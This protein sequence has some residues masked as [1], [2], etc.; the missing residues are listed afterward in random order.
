MPQNLIKNPPKAMILAA[1]LGTRLR[2]LTN[3]TPKA[4][5]QLQGHPLIAYSLRLLKKFGIQ[6]VLINLHHLGELIEKELG[7]GRKFGMKITYSW[8]PHVLGTGGGLKKAEPFFEGKPFLLMNSD[9]LIDLNLKE[10]LQFHRRKK[11]LATMV[12]RPKEADSSFT[13]IQLDRSNRVL[14]IGDEPVKK[15]AHEV[16]FTGLQILEPAFL[17]YIPSDQEACLIRNGYNPALKNSEKIY[18]MPYEGYWND[19]GTLDRYRQAELDLSSGKVN[20]S[21]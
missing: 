6:E 17:K 10:L 7:N 15:Q 2:P 12:V 5:I 11:S 16:M 4:L 19:I 9:I 14:A 3:T 18:G 13:P 1:G 21:F 8:E 20:L